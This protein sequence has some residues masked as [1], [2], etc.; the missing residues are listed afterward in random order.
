MLK[1]LLAVFAA[2]VFTITCAAAVEL[3][4]DHPDS[5]V[6]QQGDTLWSIAAKFLKQPWLWPEIWHA[7]PQIA[8]P[9]QIY[10][11][12][13]ISLAY[14][15]GG[16]PQ[17]SVVKRSPEARRTAVEPVPP[18]PLSDI[19]GFLKSARVLDDG[20]QKGL[21]YV[22]AV[23]EGR[24][25]GASGHVVYVR[26]A[27][28]RPGDEYAV[29]RPTVRYAIHPHPATHYPRVAKDEWSAEHGLM[30]R[31]PGMQFAYYAAS[32]NGFEVLGYEVV[33]VARGVI[34]RDGDPATLLLDAEG[35]EVKQ[36]DLLMPVERQPY[37]LSF[38]PHPPKALPANVRVLALTDRFAYGGKHDVIAISAG[39][40]DGVD[41]GTVLAIYRPGEKVRDDIANKP[42]IKAMMP[43]RKVKLPD[44]FVGHVM[45]F[46][47]F[48]KISYGLVMDGI[49]PVRLNDELHA[50]EN[51]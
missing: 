45:V 44:E 23:E 40:R 16:R 15:S 17:L 32:D 42:R 12:D 4:D 19:E 1:K 9:H 8:N 43:S 5:Y 10:P 50:P 26:G 41:N 28:F 21:P 36:G 34:T 14:L 30:P 47:S 18:I 3:R 13:V 24:L 22:L 25:R 6:V 46:R 48:D 49:R 2:L 20:E 37:D 7:N 27:E 38:T 11:G 39:L 29:V 35:H 33:D 51:L 31:V